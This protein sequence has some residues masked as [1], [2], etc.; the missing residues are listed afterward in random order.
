M[1]CLFFCGLIPVFICLRSKIFYKCSSWQVPMVPSPSPQPSPL[2]RGGRI[3]ARASLAEALPLIPRRMT[4]LPLPK[5]EGWG[6]GEGDEQKSASSISPRALRVAGNTWELAEAHVLAR[7]AR[8]YREW[9]LSLSA[10]G[11]SKSAKLLRLAPP[12]TPR[13]RRPLAA[14]LENRAACRSVRYSAALS[15]RKNPECNYQSDVGGGTCKRRIGGRAANSTRVAPPRYLAYE[16]AGQCGWDFSRDENCG[17]IGDLQVF[18][19]EVVAFPL[20]PA[21]SLGE[22]EERHA[23]LGVRS[24]RAMVWS[25]EG[26][27]GLGYLG[28]FG[29]EVAAFPLTPALSLGEREERHAVFE[30]GSP[31]IVD[32]SRRDS[33]GE[34]LVE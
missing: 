9:I 23:V 11:N 21:L 20:T 12:A 4:F 3:S 30:V 10:N 2:G 18:E 19:R 34:E 26:C 16:A 13:D 22:R 15:R 25:G 32:C 6:E 31:R 17:G 28:G 5:G 27:G 24:S 29:R 7:P 14:V 8:W 1:T 33:G